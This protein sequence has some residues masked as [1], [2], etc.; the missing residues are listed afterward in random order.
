MVRTGVEEIRHS[1][2]ALK[3]M[4]K[5]RKRGQGLAKPISSK[6]DLDLIL[7][8]TTFCMISAGRN[9]NSASDAKL[10]ERDLKLRDGK[11]R[12]DL[13]RKGYVFTP[14]KGKYGAPE[15]S[16]FVMC[17]DADRRDLMSLGSK[18]HQDSILFVQDGSSELIQTT[19]ENAGSA[20]MEGK[21]HEYVPDADDFYTEIDVGGKPTKFVMSLAEIAKAI[22]RSIVR[23]FKIRSA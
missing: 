8:K 16:L 22:A 14:A 17:H 6:A 4:Y 11:L 15:E 9:P 18:Y 5:K 23:L 13:I 20:V 3:V 12:S 2:D 21:G 19:G 10:T 1:I 7:T